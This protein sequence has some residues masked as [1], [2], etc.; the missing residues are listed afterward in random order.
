MEREHDRFNHAQA[1]F[2]GSDRNR[3]RCSSSCGAG[4]IDQL[5]C[6]YGTSM[7]VTASVEQR[8]SSDRSVPPPLRRRVFR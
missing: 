5:S 1:E 7:E 2:A 3:K 4:D 6:I 8:D